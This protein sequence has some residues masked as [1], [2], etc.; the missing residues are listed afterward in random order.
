M[1]GIIYDALLDTETIGVYSSW[2]YGRSL[3]R[4]QST[5]GQTLS[6]L[7]VKQNER[8]FRY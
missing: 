2:A 4:I 5:N 1:Y 8:L 3:P 6:S 7:Q